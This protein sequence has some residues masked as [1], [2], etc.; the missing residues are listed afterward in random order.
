MEFTATCK[1]A[2]IIAAVI[3]I[4]GFAAIIRSTSHDD[5]A[6]SIG[7]ACLVMVALTITICVLVRHWIVNTN[8]ERTGLA[9]ATREA[10]AQRAFYQAAQCALEN[11]QGRLNRDMAIERAKIAKTLITERAKMTAEFNEERALLAADAFRTGVEMERAGALKR[12]PQPPANL[13][14]FPKQEKPQQAS[15]PQHERS[16]EHGVVGP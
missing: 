8:T 16:R 3:L 12:A 14:P 11:E 5:V 7:G 6:G 15:A 10:Q 1:A 13:I 2:S 9:A 4:S